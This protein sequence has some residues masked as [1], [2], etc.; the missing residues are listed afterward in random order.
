MAKSSQAVVFTPEDGRARLKERYERLPEI[1][2]TLLELLSVNYVPIA[3]SQ[4]LVCLN[5][6][7]NQTQATKS[8]TIKDL[9]SYLSRLIQQELVVIHGGHGPQCH[10][11]VVEIVT[12]N[13]IAKK[14]FEALVETIEKVLP[15]PAPPWN[16]NR[17][18]FENQGQLVREVRI[19]LYRRNWA[20]IEEQFEA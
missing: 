19:G 9:A 8:L 20:Y 3:K 2:Q 12:R 1:E 15:I 16:R 6:Y 11:L 17:P 7:R 5:I 10:P 18:L 13:T 14:H 4:L